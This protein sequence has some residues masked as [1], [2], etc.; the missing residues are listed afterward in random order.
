CSLQPSAIQR[1]APWETRDVRFHFREDAPT[2]GREEA[3]AG[4]T[5]EPIHAC[6]V[7]QSAIN[8]PMKTTL[9][10]SL[11]VAALALS[12]CNSSMRSSNTDPATSTS[13][14]VYSESSASTSANTNA[15][16]T[17]DSSAW[18]Q[19]STSTPGSGS[20][21]TGDYSSSTS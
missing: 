17:T 20:S 16:A 18:N 7:S 8:S 10:F 21:T 1:R 19:S 14:P 3:D 4:M 12:G 6:A 9:L 11:I 5:R 2:R 15:N 13:T